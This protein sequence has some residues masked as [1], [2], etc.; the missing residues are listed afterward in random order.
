MD[1]KLYNFLEDLR[2]EAHAHTHVSLFRPKGTF[3]IYRRHADKFWKTYSKCMVEIDEF[4]T[5]LAEA[6]G[7]YIPI[8]V[9]VD[10]NREFDE[11]INE[12]LP[13]IYKD[14]HVSK[15]IGI[16]QDVIKE[17][18]DDCENKHLYC[19]FLN[20][21]PYIKLK[22][23]G[24]KIL[25]HG[26]HLHFPYLFLNKIEQETHLIPRIKQKLK[27]N[28][29][30]YDIGECD[31]STVID[32]SYLKNHW[33]MYGAQK[34]EDFDP[35]L[36][37]AMYN[38]KL[39]EMTLEEGLENYEIYDNKEQ[40]IRFKKSIGYYLPRILSINP[41]GREVSEL[42]P[43]LPS[44]LQRKMAK[45]QVRKISSHSN[46]LEKLQIYKKLVDC[47]DGSRA[48][49]YSEW[50]N[51]GFVLYN[52]SN[53]SDEGRELWKEFSQKCES[54][55]DAYVCDKAWDRMVKKNYTDRTLYL[56]AE[57]DDPVEFKKIQNKDIKKHLDDSLNG[58]H[59]DI[60][61]TLYSKY[62]TKFVCASIKHKIW[63]HFVDH[64][65]HEVECGVTLKKKIST[66]ILGLYQ[67]AC[68]EC[69]PKIASDDVGEKAMYEARM[70][71]LMKLMSSLKNANFKSNVMKECMEVF[72]N[73][74]FLKSLN[75]NAYLIG[76]TNG[77][78]DLRTHSFR[79]GIPDDFISL[80]MAIDYKKFEPNSSD[81]T[82][83][84]EF[85][86]KVFPDKSVR[87]YFL[88]TSS[89]IFV[90]GNHNKLVQVWS[91]E[92]DNAKS[93]TQILFEK[94]FG[95]YAVKLPTS[96]IIGKRT[97]SS[98]ACPELVRAGN[99][100]RFAVL[101]EP[102][103]KDVI[104]IGILK[105]LSGNDTFFARG[106]FKEGG[107]ITPMFK[108]ILI[109]NEPPKLPYGDKAVWNRIRVV[110]FEST[111]V[112]PSDKDL[113]ETY[114]EQLKEKKFPKD[115][116]FAD[117]I[118]GM[119]EAF[120]FILLEHRKTLNKRI[121]PKKVRI[122]TEGYRLKNDIYRQFIEESIVEDN[123]FSLALVELYS[124]FKEWFKE[125]MPNHQIPVK[126]DLC[127]YFTKA[128]GEA[129]KGI[130]WKGK[131]LRTLKD[132]IDSGD[133]L[134]F[135]EEELSTVSN[136]FIPGL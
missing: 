133:A 134:V 81:V 72:H 111:F 48:E 56:W 14:F 47:L 34:G 71:Q 50:I 58:S 116:Q 130:K 28:P 27:K 121:E 136:D 11:D 33:L 64:C 41:Y 32:A 103:Q 51:V 119:I 18:V 76:F 118:P 26:F 94:M 16:Y 80:Q 63:Y 5:G 132:D 8:L 115:P 74:T 49:N 87:N 106:L 113:P 91:G 90:G 126:N 97:Q 46:F 54:K 22:P 135:S 38:E 78:Y 40:Q 7:P 52:I 128:W 104:N 23:N 60:A 21:D 66:E 69:I 98:A 3:S 92:G 9:D 29:I 109:C 125:S 36:I 96:L 77:V 83:V 24:I 127:T 131:R 84:H 13:P 17:I 20:K 55:Y 102:D 2:C 122:A 86:E 4:K 75:K 37:A 120:A 101:Q 35:Y 105:E 45:R 39:E 107:E 57:Q 12:E 129:A 95:K 31:S 19:I 67:K 85:L 1:R 123:K 117:K 30:F 79:D 6:S 61:M 99:G 42:K 114:E 59:F 110:P 15:L 65:W 73:G 43:N 88:D 68:Y 108:L 10:L 89:D 100:V 82:E 93:I 62:R 44:P 70:K 25:K 53:G 112:D 124:A